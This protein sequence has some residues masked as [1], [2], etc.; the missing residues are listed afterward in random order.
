MAFHVVESID[1]VLWGEV[2]ERDVFDIA[3]RP[4]VPDEVIIQHACFPVGP[5]SVTSL[6]LVA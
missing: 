4:F 1:N 3:A 2:V 5:V 6:R